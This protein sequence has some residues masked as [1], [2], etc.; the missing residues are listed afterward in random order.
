MFYQEPCVNFGLYPV[1]IACLQSEIYRHW[2]KAAATF[3]RAESANSLSFAQKWCLYMWGAFF[4]MGAYKCDVVVIH[5]VLF[6]CG[7]LLSWFYGMYRVSI[8]VWVLIYKCNVVVVIKMGSYIHGCLFSM[9]AI[10]PILVQTGILPFMS[11]CMSPQVSSG[12]LLSTF[13]LESGF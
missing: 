9:G 7:C 12:S 11:C 8:F 13:K 1:V 10:I 2:W 5:G 6:L 4:S 3:K